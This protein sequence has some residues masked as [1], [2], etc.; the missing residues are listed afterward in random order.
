MRS[1]RALGQDAANHF[2]MEPRRRCDPVVSPSRRGEAADRCRLLQ[3]AE[4]VPVSHRGALRVGR[5][6]GVHCAVVTRGRHQPQGCGAAS[7][8]C[9][10]SS[11]PGQNTRPPFRMTEISPALISR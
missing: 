5:G 2:T 6:A 7:V 11:D 4:R 10:I 3:L 8:E 1:R 9:R